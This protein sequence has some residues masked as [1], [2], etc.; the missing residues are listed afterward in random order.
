MPWGGH[1][2][3]FYETKQ[4]LMDTLVPYFKAG[5]KSNEFCVWAVTDPITIEEARAALDRAIPGLQD[6]LSAGQIEILHGY[7]WYLSQDLKKV[8]SSW[9]EKLHDA[10]TK[11]HEGMRASGNAFWLGTKYRDDFLAYEQ[12]L[13]QS[14]AGR[15]MLVL[16][17]Y[18]LQASRAADILDVAHA[19]R[20]TAARR[21]GEWELIE[22][23][24]VPTITHSLTLREV[25]VLSWV[26]RG[27]SAWEIGKIL[28]ISKRTVDEHVRSAG[29]K[30]G[31]ANRTEAAALALSR[32]IIE[33]DPF[34]RA[35]RQR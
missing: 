31:A 9:H 6:Y 5:L 29:Q 22:T 15:R 28:G 3:V 23:A 18:P 16:C 17:T 34:V 30:L 11:G 32:N 4:D 33:L 26:A 20:V 24:E 8:T 14:L 19:H 21:N 35:A 12:E 27:K 10:L 1:L 25:E 2:C 7:E 13:D